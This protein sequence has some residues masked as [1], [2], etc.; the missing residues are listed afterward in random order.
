MFAS[1]LSQI[2]SM[3]CRRPDYASNANS[4]SF[5]T[6]FRHRVDLINS[7]EFF[8]VMLTRFSLFLDG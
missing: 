2:T 1:R 8:L 7:Q 4:G 3:M 5:C 6:I